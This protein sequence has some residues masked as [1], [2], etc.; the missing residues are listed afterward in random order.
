MIEKKIIPTKPSHGKVDFKSK[1]QMVQWNAS[2]FEKVKDHYQKMQDLSWQVYLWA[3]AS[4]REFSNYLRVKN[5]EVLK[6]IAWDSYSYAKENADSYSNELNKLI[7]E[8]EKG[9]QK[10]KYSDK[11]NG[12]EL[13]KVKVEPQ[14]I[15]IDKNSI[16]LLM[17]F[18]VYPF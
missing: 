4:K 2:D 16:F 13:G 1:A 18:R 6:R 11:K 3:E 8:L 14:K 12:F 17:L 7:D 10:Y 5:D 15:T 9:C